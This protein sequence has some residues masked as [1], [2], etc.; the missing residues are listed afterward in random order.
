MKSIRFAPKFGHLLLS[1]SADTKVKI[2]DVYNKRQCMRTYM[3]HS[4]GI[5]EVN[6]N[7][8][9]DQFLSCSFDKTVKL[10]DVES[11]VCKAR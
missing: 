6:F 9:G 10:W 3:G 8:K 4:A 5:K 2:W 1:G 11:G 7:V